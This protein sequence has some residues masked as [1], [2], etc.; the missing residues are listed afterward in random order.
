MFTYL[1]SKRHYEDLYDEMTV[2][3]CLYY[4]KIFK[5]GEPGPEKEEE[6]RVWM[7]V[8][9]LIMYF[10]KGRR[11]KERESTIQQW[12]N[13]D[14]EKDKR[15]ENTTLDNVECPH[16]YSSNMEFEV[17][18]LDDDHVILFYKCSDCEKRSA[19]NE[20][21]ERM[22]FKTKCPNCESILEFKSKREKD[23]IT[24]YHKCPNC[25]Y[26]EEPMIELLNEKIKK[27]NSWKKYREEYCLSE[28]QGRKYIDE[29]MNLKNM[30]SFLKEIE[31]RKA[32][33]EV[34]K[35]LEELKKLN[36]A[37]LKELLNISLIKNNYIQLEFLEPEIGKD[38]IVSFKVQ[39][40]DTKRDEYKS[41]IELK[42][43]I[44]ENLKN[45]NWKLMSNDINYRLGFIGGRLR[46]YESREDLLKLVK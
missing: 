3:H 16:C 33:K 42:K 4:K 20:S 21:G 30:E 32:N 2:E 24:S 17:K 37:Q 35:K 13:A 46:G 18:S 1:S 38:I 25:N 10:E 22:T 28:E 43:L 39:D 6:R 29:E 27:D 23:K 31:E 12:M 26:K 11:Y 44:E 5:E 40:D 41:K 19:F 8:Y 9:T 14:I 7:V 45:T 15:L 36:V 34:Y